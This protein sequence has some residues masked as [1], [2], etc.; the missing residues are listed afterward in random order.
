MQSARALGRPLE[1]A[2]AAAG[3]CDLTEW[4]PRDDEARA[5]LEEALAAIPADTAGGERALLLTRLAYLSA[6]DDVAGAEPRAREALVRARQLGD[7]ALHQDAAYVLHFLLAGPDHLDERADLAREV[8]EGAEG[9]GARDTA[10]ITVLDWACDRLTLGDAAGARERRA[11]AAELA[12]PEPHPGRAWHLRVFDAGFAW[13][14]GRLDEAARLTGEA[15]RLG[16][17]IAHPYA[18]GVDRVLRAGLARERG[19]EAEVLRVFDP[20]LPIRQGP[21]QWVQAFTARALVAT[22]R[23]AEARAFFEDLASAGFERIPRNIRWHGTLV[24]V[25]HLCAE[26]GDAERARSLVEILAPVEHQHGVLPMPICYGGPVARCL[27][28]L[29]ALLGRAGEAE[30]LYLEALDACATLGARPMQARVGVE[31]GTLVARRDRARGRERLAE[32]ER[33]AGELGLAGVA[34]AARAALARA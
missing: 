10:L 3:F 31:L 21:M 12:G 4:A 26:L 23:E 28:R 33:L 32:A 20:E 2:R 19:D 8:L 9:A 30:E 15:S 6:R 25:A 16:Q 22:G 1:F 11:E 29:H 34:S 5:A 14:E 18:R 13:L 7:P 24:E 17:R 27:A